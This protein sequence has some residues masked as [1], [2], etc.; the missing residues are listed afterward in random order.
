[1][2]YLLEEIEH[3]CHN[4]EILETD[5]NEIK[6]V[7]DLYKDKCIEVEKLKNEIN[8]LRKE[9]VAYER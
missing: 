8:E 2:Q 9:R 4:Y 1:M 3:L 7:Y 5:N 6:K